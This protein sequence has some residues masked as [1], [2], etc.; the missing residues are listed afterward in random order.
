MSMSDLLAL[1]AIEESDFSEADDMY[2]M[3]NLTKKERKVFDR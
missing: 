2:L 3:D 1:Y